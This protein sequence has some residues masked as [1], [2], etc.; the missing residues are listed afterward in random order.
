VKRALFRKSVLDFI[1]AGEQAVDKGFIGKN[2]HI[3]DN[4]HGF[5]MSIH[6]E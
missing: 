4:T 3:E 2:P 6:F 1:N 5:A